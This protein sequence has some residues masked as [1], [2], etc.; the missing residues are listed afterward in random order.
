MRWRCGVCDGINLDGDT[1]AICG[2]SR[3]AALPVEPPPTA[4][5]RRR[6]RVPDGSSRRARDFDASLRRTRDLDAAPPLEAPKLPQD[7][8]GPRG[9]LRRL[10]DAASR[11]IERALSGIPPT[12]EMPPEPDATSASPRRK[13]RWKVRPFPFGILVTYE[14]DPDADSG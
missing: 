10:A 2:A 8:P 9:L 5:S 11:A 3:A 12:D 1:C 13:S 4:P 14:D 6:S 7:A